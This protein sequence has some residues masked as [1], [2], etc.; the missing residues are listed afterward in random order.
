M[1]IYFTSEFPIDV[2]EEAEKI[3][4]HKSTGGCW[5]LSVEWLK[6]M[7]FDELSE[8]NNL[9]KAANSHFVDK[10]NGKDETYYLTS[11]KLKQRADS[12]LNKLRKVVLAGNSTLLTDAAN[13]R[14]QSDFS[15]KQFNR[16][17]DFH[18]FNLNT[19]TNNASDFLLFLN[20]LKRISSR[21]WLFH[22]VEKAIDSLCFTNNQDAD[23][24]LVFLRYKGDSQAHA[25]ALYSPSIVRNGRRYPIGYMMGFDSNSGEFIFDIPTSPYWI[26]KIAAFKKEISAISF[27]YV[28]KVND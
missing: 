26:K 6:L 1:P 21:D 4:N 10:N 19:A 11:N 7:F 2:Y 17:N 25:V 8:A 23:G 3:H 16:T 9:I 22:G 28:Q 27:T 20:G 15:V 14:V 12:R 24:I 5:A 18:M 13:Y